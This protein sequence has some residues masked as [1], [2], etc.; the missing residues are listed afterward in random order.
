M[1]L[2]SHFLNHR[3]SQT[4]QGCGGGTPTFE[5]DWPL[6]GPIS[7]GSSMHSQPDPE[8]LARRIAGARYVSTGQ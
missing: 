5:H 7:G 1:I 6:A 4:K 8:Q 3:T 2:V